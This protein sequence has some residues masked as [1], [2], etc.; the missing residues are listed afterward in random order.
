MR[1]HELAALSDAE[2]KRLCGVSRKTFGDMVEVLRPRLARQGRR[3]G[4][5][6]LSVEDHLLVALEYG[7]EYRSQFHSGVSWGLHETSVGRII[8]KVEDELVKCGKFRLPSHRQ[9][10][11]SDWEWKVFVVDVSEME[12]E[13]PKKQK[14]YYSGKQKCHTLKAQL[15]VEFDTGQ[16]ICTSVATGKTHDFKLLKRSRLP[17]VASQLC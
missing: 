5:A 2:F 16:V 1:Y 8:K 4:Q 14:R 15:L 12:I 3:G 11:Q 7:H 10:Y 9:L 6:K 17:F 13:R